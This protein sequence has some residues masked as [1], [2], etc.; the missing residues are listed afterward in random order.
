MSSLHKVI[1]AG[2]VFSRLDHNPDAFKG[3]RQNFLCKQRQHDAYN[4]VMNKN[5]HI[6]FGSKAQTRDET[7]ELT[8]FKCSKIV[9]KSVC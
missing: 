5:A 7:S 8:S 4:A 2:R 3:F 1:C 9:C 6:R